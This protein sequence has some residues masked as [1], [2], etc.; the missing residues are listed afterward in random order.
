MTI[1]E[2]A[3]QLVVDN[4]PSRYAKRCTNSISERRD[5]PHPHPPAHTR[6]FY[7][8]PHSIFPGFGAN[9]VPWDL[10]NKNISLIFH[11][12][13]FWFAHEI[14]NYKK[15]NRLSQKFALNPAFIL[16]VYKVRL[17]ERLPNMVSKL[18]LDNI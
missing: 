15:K 6:A 8:A 1:A 11:K 3:V 12:T 5:Y 14:L 4:W 9:S 10:N 2:C 13:A 17:N 18:S 16:G 7:I